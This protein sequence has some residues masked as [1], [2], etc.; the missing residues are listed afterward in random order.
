[1]RKLVRFAELY[2][3]VQYND[4]WMSQSKVKERL[5]R[6]KEGRKRKTV[7]DD[8]KQRIQENR[9]ISFEGTASEMSIIWERRDETLAQG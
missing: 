9:K 6:F 5:D 2:P 7:L 4:N 8:V 1:M 3:A